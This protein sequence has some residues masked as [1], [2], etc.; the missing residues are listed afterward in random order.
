M[1]KRKNAITIRR[2]KRRDNILLTQTL[3]TR[4]RQTWQKVRQSQRKSAKIRAVIL[5]KSRK[6]ENYRNTVLGRTIIHKLPPC[7]RERQRVRREYLQFAASTPPRRR[8]AG[9]AS[10]RFTMRKCK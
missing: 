7:K 4:D 10:E 1:R 5:G 8:R 9:S 2:N 3:R 6:P